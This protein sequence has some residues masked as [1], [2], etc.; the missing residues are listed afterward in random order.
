MSSSLRRPA[1][2]LITTSL[3]A[4]VLGVAPAHAVIVDDA[5]S[6]HVTH[7]DGPLTSAVRVVAWLQD[8]ED[9]TY[10]EDVAVD[11]DGAYSL[12]GLAPGSYRVVF[13]SPTDDYVY[14]AYDNVLD[15]DQART[16]VVGD[17]V[18]DDAVDADLALAGHVV[19]SVGTASGAAAV[20]AWVSLWHEVTSAEDG[21][22]WE[23]TQYGSDVDAETGAYDVDGVPA[24]TYRV[25][26]Y[27]DGYQR[28]FY[29]DSA[30]VEGGTDVAV[31]EGG[32]EELPAA[33]LEEYSSISGRVTDAGDLPVAGAEVYAL[34]DE[35]NVVDWAT[36]G[37]DGTYVINGLADDAY[38]VEFYD[39]QDDTAD[40]GEY[41]DNVGT[42]EEA[43][44]VTT[45]SGE[46]SG[47]V[48][49]K[50]VEGEHDPVQ[51][52]YF[53]NTAAPVI[54]G[55]AQVGSTLTATAGSWTPAPSGVEYYWFRN[56]DEWIESANGPTYQLTA[57]DLGKRIT[58]LVAV[59]GDGHEPTYA[60][61]EPTAPVAA[62]PAPPVVTPPVVTPP[63]VTPPAPVV[64]APAALAA[65]V[66]GIDVAGKPKVGATLKLT[67]LD[68]LFRA[69]TPVSYTFQWYAGSAK[70][71]KAT[72][73]KLKVLSS[74]KGKKLSV[75]VTASAGSTKKTVKIKVGTV[76]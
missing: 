24:G 32:T 18:A 2:A 62:A 63:V 42:F 76:R 10:A 57:A 35:Q 3:A 69:S 53:D 59:T 7:D 8:G 66:E 6:G 13:E 1:V 36:T 15:F 17:G 19:G 71:K 54:S 27:A 25:E 40:L 50:L 31:T 44:P 20:D 68:K 65:I 38:V 75:K 67:G 4:T 64:S 51:L 60:I 72:K 26:F 12:V 39:Y 34:D 29:E 28:E 56:E 73:S 55:A 49:A 45:V 33:E 41:Y 43:T 21:T 16:V 14:E 74:M 23:P 70:I 46:D 9:W 11:E 30:T 47:S 5:I 22:T 52:P 58:V 48:D 61:S 37:D